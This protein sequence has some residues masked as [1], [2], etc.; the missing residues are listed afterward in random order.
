LAQRG[1]PTASADSDSNSES[2]GYLDLIDALTPT[3]VWFNFFHLEVSLCDLKGSVWIQ[4][5]F[6]QMA[7]D[8]LA[9]AVSL[10]RSRSSKIYPIARPAACFVPYRYQRRKPFHG[11]E[12]R[13]YDAKET[14]DD[15]YSGSIGANDYTCACDPMTE[16]CKSHACYFQGFDNEKWDKQQRQ[17]FV[18][19]KLLDFTARQCDYRHSPLAPYFTNRGHVSQS[20]LHPHSVKLCDIIRFRAG[21]RMSWAA[22]KAK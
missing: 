19:S 13:L 14:I 9:A 4:R 21:T 2:V 6:D 18:G 15:Q 20:N 11:Q 12:F 3:L 17:R 22:T 10:R 5:S 1:S 8:E 7:L 16:T